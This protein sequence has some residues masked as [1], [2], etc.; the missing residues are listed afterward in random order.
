M[1][2]KISWRQLALVLGVGIL[3]LGLSNYD[4][5]NGSIFDGPAKAA[6]TIGSGLV[7]LAVV[8]RPGN[9]LGD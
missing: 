6:L 8:T 9:G 2:L 5:R 1:E 4:R 3:V 7:S